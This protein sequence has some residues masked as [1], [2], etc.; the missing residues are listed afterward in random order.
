MY[1]KQ[2]YSLLLS[3]IFSPN[4]G[5]NGSLK[6][7]SIH[8][9]PLQSVQH[10]P[11]LLKALV[12][13]SKFLLLFL[14]H[15][16]FKF[17]G[18]PQFLQRQPCLCF[19]T[20]LAPPSDVTSKQDISSSLCP[21]LAKQCLAHLS[22]VSSNIMPLKIPFLTLQEMRLW[23]PPE[24]CASLS[25]YVLPPWLFKNSGQ[26]NVCLLNMRTITIVSV[27]GMAQQIKVFTNICL[28]NHN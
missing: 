20:P 6:C 22:G 12:I 10:F 8:I 5:Q 23:I 27:R 4:I 28:N 13:P 7:I 24:F 14:R 15:E 3:E 9:T 1:L 21:S 2:K 26:L 18:L 17:S 19:S 25:Q 16:S 11:R